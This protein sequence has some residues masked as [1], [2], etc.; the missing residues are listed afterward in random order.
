[1]ISERAKVAMAAMLVK[2]QSFYCSAFN[3]E[4]AS[5]IPPE[6][7]EKF[8]VAGILKLETNDSRGTIYVAVMEKTIGS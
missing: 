2:I 6:E 3:A 4:K 5:V 8:G 1:M 7:H